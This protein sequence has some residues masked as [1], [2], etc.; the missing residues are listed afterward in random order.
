MSLLNHV[1]C[2]PASKVIYVQTRLC[3]KVV[4]VPTC[5]KGANLSFSGA[6]KRANVFKKQYLK[7][8][9]ILHSYTSCYIK[10][11]CLEFYFCLFCSFIR[12]ENI[13]RPD[14]YTLQVTR[15]FSN[16][17]QLKKLSKLKNTC[18][19]CDILELWSAWVGDPR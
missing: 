13:K 18:E 5:Q 8:C 14:F 15:V 4:Y 3:A 16:F 12:N 9:I 17:P 10:E 2:V 6:N 1:P 19:F 11:K 7:S